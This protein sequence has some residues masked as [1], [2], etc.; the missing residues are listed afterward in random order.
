MSDVDDLAFD[1]AFALSQSRSAPRLGSASAPCPMRRST[2][3][4]G[5]LPGISLTGAGK[6]R[7]RYRKLLSDPRF[8]P[9]SRC[10]SVIVISVM[11]EGWG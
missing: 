1:I 9:S 11:R 6:E 10:R 5:S 3:C 7:Q 8:S 2:S 4:R